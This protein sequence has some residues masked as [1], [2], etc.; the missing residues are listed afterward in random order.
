MNAIHGLAQSSQPGA[1]VELFD[2]DL[3]P[4]GGVTVEHFTMS[5]LESGPVVWNGNTYQPIDVE[6][7]GFEW[8][9]QGQLPR[10]KLSVT[11]VNTVF[12]ALVQDFGDL[13]GARVTRRRTFRQ[14][15]DGEPGAD[16][17]AHFSPDIFLVERKVLQSP[18]IIEWE[19][20]AA[21]D[22]EGRM[23][24]RRQ[25]IR[26]TCTHTYRRWNTLTGS[27]DYSA[28]TCP[29]GEAL[30]FDRLGQATTAANDRCGKRLS[31]CK[32]RFG[33]YG[34]LYHRGFPGAGKVRP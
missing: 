22:Q 8:S 29:F 4:I 27:F 7:S 34:F 16:V 28:A 13:V 11:N 10:P 15:L 20:S 26:D 1:Y 6:A 30:Y 21:L 17:G 9:G 24:P 32:L 2:L 31:D 12:A 5:K 19:L 25:V 33:I 23:L 3:T 14:F 18:A